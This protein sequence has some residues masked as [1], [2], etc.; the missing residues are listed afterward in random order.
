MVAELTLY[1]KTP[2]SESG[3]LV[4]NPT[5][6]ALVV[7]FGNHPRRVDVR[8]KIEI[9]VAVQQVVFFIAHDSD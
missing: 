1:R 4:C 8:N 5:I 3:T 9:V 2:V 6:A 7:A